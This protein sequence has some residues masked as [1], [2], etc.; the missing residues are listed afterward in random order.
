MQL[1]NEIYLDDEIE[2]IDLYLKLEQ[3]RFQD[4]FDYEINCEASVLNNNIK[5]VI[6]EASYIAEFKELSIKTDIVVKSISKPIEGFN[7][8][9]GQNV[10][11]FIIHLN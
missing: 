3:M 11:I 4:K 2:R 9:K 7:Y 8:S 10:E 5:S 6:I 1:V